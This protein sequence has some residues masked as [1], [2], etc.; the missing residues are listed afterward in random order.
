MSKGKLVGIIAFLV[1][2]LAGTLGYYLYTLGVISLPKKE[3]A[4]QAVS[5]LA[6]TIKPEEPEEKY[7]GSTIAIYTEVG[8]TKEDVEKYAEDFDGQVLVSVTSESMGTN[9]GGY[10]EIVLKETV[11]EKDKANFIKEITNHIAVKEVYFI[12]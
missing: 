10:Y 7:T 6:G 3:E 5:E 4:T 9:I 8:I 2:F 11:P 1:V 12:N